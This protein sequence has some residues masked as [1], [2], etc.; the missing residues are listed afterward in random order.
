MKTIYE[1]TVG[2]DGA[3]MGA[4]VDGDWVIIQEK[5]PL[6]KAIDPADKFLDSSIDKLEEKFGWS[7]AFL[8]PLR[9]SA[10][11]ALLKLVGG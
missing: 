3:V 11:A 8:E 9:V 1:H 4:Y 10:K 7:K 5:Y 2:G 6:S